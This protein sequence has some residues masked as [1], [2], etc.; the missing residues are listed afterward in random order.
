MI[1]FTFTPFLLYAYLAIAFFPLINSFKF[2]FFFYSFLGELSV[3]Y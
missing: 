1:M 3:K 2:L